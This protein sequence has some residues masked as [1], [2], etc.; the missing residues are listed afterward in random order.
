MPGRPDGC[1]TL[2]V[3]LFVAVQPSDAVLDVVAGLARPERPGVRWTT[4]PQWH[5]TLRFLGEVDDPAPVVAALEAAPL[6]PCEAVAGPR[7]AALGRSAV[8]VPVAGLDTLAA[9][10]VRATAGF[11]APAGPRAFH[12]HL[13]IARVRRGPVRDLVGEAVAVRFAVD[14]VR[15]VRS[16]LG[17]SGARYEDLH[18]RRLTGP[19][20]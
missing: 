12:G 15:L 9:G 11:G 17:A 8:V 18:V 3:R 1:E 16:H 7:V 4:R 2:P 19:G 14:D 5:V 20:A 10:V 13:T 6:A